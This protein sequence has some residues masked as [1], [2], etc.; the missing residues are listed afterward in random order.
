MVDFP[1]SDVGLQ[2]ISP[3]LPRARR[4]VTRRGVFPRRGFWWPAICTEGLGNESGNPLP[5]AQK[6]GRS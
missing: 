1:A 4:I 5:S 3:C 2:G 6:P